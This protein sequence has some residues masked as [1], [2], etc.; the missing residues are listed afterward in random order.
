MQPRVLL[1]GLAMPESPRW[2]ESRLWLSNWGTRQILAVDLD[3][4][5]DVVGE[6]WTLR[7][8][9][10]CPAYRCLVEQRRWAEAVYLSAIRPLTPPVL[11]RKGRRM[12]HPSDARTRASVA[13]EGDI[14]GSL[15]RIRMITGRV[16]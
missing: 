8:G 13:G 10:R 4:N 6:G 2:H 15:Y 1:D 7:C 3:G 5:S 11:A 16:L 12:L 14:A 9:T